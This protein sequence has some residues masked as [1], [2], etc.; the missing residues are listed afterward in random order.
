VK[1]A[2]APQC[3]AGTDTTGGYLQDAIDR[4]RFGTPAPEPRAAA[5]GAAG[6][7]EVTEADVVSQFGTRLVPATFDAPSGHLALT[8]GTEGIQGVS[9]GAGYRVRTDDIQL[10]KLTLYQ[11]S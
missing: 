10:G 6:A 8:T 1:F 4:L 3:L 2:R 11:L 7:R 9:V 5:A